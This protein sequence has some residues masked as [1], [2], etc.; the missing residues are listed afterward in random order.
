MQA[1]KQASPSVTSPNCFIPLLRPPGPRGRH[2][3]DRCIFAH[4]SEAKR[5][6]ANGSSSRNIGNLRRALL[7]L[8]QYSNDLIL[9]AQRRGCSRFF[10]TRSGS[11]KTH[12]WPSSS[13]DT[14]SFRRHPA[15]GISAHVSRVSTHSI[16]NQFDRLTVA[17]H[18]RRGMAVNCR[19][20]KKTE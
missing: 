9:E 5:R 1:S 19:E 6:A 8:Q 16:T 20:G 11:T 2:D 18:R 10:T 17:H 15:A 14:R 4:N 7:L 12:Q 3:G 13:R